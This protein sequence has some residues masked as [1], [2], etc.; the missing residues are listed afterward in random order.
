LGRSRKPTALHLVQGTFNTTRHKARADEPEVIEP[1]GGPPQDW[2]VD[3]KL[4]W[5][6]VADMLP[7]GV[8]TRSDRLM[9]ETLCRLVAQMREGPAGLSPALATQ[10]RMALAVFGMTPAD[11]SRVT[12]ARAPEENPFSKL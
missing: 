6:E 5:A 9:F 12:A 11:R 3:G 1:L 8:A 4:L 7:A 10:I 2:P